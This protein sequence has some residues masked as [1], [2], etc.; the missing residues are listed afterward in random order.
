[1]KQAHAA[2]EVIR[3]DITTLDMDAIVNAANESLLGGGGVDGAIHRAAGPSLLAACRALPEVRPG[4]RCPTGEARV[5]A[6]FALP[7]RHV[8]HT[9]GPVWRGGKAGEPGLLASCYRH[10]LQLARELGAAGVA[11]PAISCGVYG[12]PVDAAATVAVTCVREELDRHGHPARVLLCCFD[13]PARAA[14]QAAL[15]A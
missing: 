6:G 5:T 15:D 4:V 2:I 9:V 3:A 10:S 13:E 7:A 12:Y 8:I 1:M 11:F 14:F